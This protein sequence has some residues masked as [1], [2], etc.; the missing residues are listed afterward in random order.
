MED[1]LSLAYRLGILLLTL[2]GWLCIYFFVNRRSVE[3]QRRLNL[4]T[5]F[6]KNLPFIPQFAIIYFSTYLFVIQPFFILSDAKLFYWMVAC[7]V[8][9]SI[10]ASLIHALLPSKIERVEHISTNRVYGKL[11]NRFQQTCKPYGNFPSMHVGLSVPVVIAN[12]MV[13]NTAAGGVMLVWGVSIA[14][15]TMFTKQHYLWD[16]LAG[17]FVGIAVSYLYLGMM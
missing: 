11:L 2:L 9:I 16:V 3:D 12:Y 17:L 10:G 7:F 14:L 4:S 8:S 1:S 15:S 6:D 5:T 13:S